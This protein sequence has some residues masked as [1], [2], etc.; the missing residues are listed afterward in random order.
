MES[1]ARP[2]MSRGL[3]EREVEI[4]KE[5]EALNHQLSD[6]YREQD[7]VVRAGH[8]KEIAVAQLKAKHRDVLQLAGVITGGLISGDKTAADRTGHVET[9]Y[10][11]AE[12]LMEKCEGNIQEALSRLGH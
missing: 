4:Q 3:S 12:E 6:L 10:S 1:L 8:E 2:M 7:S 11:L 5:I 9:A